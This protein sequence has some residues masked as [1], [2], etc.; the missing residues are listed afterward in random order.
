MGDAEAPLAAGVIQ[1][2]VA[3]ELAG[4]RLDQVLARL[5]PALSR[6]RL[7]SWIDAGRVDTGMLAA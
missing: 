3:P 1:Q 7:K 5:V 6:A 2:V 4:L